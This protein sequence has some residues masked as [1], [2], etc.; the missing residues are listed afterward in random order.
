MNKVY[1]WSGGDW[2]LH[3]D[4]KIIFASKEDI[5]KAIDKVLNNKAIK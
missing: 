3:K 2:I 1:Y 5:Q 4:G